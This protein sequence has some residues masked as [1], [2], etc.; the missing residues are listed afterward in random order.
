MNFERFGIVFTVVFVGYMGIILILLADQSS[1][2][3]DIPTLVISGIVLIL[4]S[5]TSQRKKTTK[6]WIMTDKA[7]IIFFALG[8]F[9][10]LGI[11]L[12]IKSAYEIDYQEAESIDF[13]YGIPVA[14]G[15]HAALAFFT[16]MAMAVSIIRIPKI[17]R[18]LKRVNNTRWIPFVGG[19][20]VGFGIIYA[21]N[22]FF[23]GIPPLL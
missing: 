14:I 1:S 22:F 17:E 12:G 9:C 19:G 13:T 3:S 21:Y 18:K 23:N 6:K 16:L 10:G 5:Y 2:D 11:L 15:G 7:Y 8:V 20:T 4:F